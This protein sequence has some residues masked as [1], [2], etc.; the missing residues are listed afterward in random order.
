MVE[1][2]TP[3]SELEAVRSLIDAYGGSGTAA[4]ERA[5]LNGMSAEDLVFAMTRAAWRT[6]TGNEEFD[7]YAVAPGLLDPRVFDQ[8]V[9]WVDVTGTPRML[10]KLSDDHLRNVIA[11]LHDGA[12]AIRAA[13][14]AANGRRV[15]R[16]S[17][18][19]WL[20]KTALAQALR[21][22]T[23]RRRRRFDTERGARP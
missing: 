23:D 17:D 20:A 2:G 8:S 13:H 14:Q 9:W 15:P 12:R 7:P 6:T 3:D 11:F 10:C 1:S 4:V 18:A 5:R 19:Q 22:E 21:A 16:V